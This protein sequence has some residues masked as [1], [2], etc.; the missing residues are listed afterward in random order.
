MRTMQKLLRLR[1]SPFYNDN[2]PMFE[3]RLPEE[4]GNNKKVNKLD[5]LHVFQGSGIVKIVDNLTSAD[6]LS[7]TTNAKLLCL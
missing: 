3:A 2:M 4:P 5:F 6:L 1:K 7:Y